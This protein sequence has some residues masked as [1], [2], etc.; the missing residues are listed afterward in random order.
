[1]FMGIINPLFAYKRMGTMMG[2]VAAT[3]VTITLH[4]APLND[5]TTGKLPHSDRGTLRRY[6]AYSPELK[7]NFTVDV[8]IPDGYDEAVTTRYPVLY[9]H[10]GQNLFDPSI[11]YAGVAW[12]VEQTLGNLIDRDIIKT[13]IVVGIHNRGSK[14][15]SDY[16]PAKPATDYIAADD[17]DASGMWTLVGNSFNGDAYATFIAKTLKPAIDA[18][19][20][21][22][23]DR[24]NTFIMGSS[25]GGL[26]SLYVMCEYPDIFGAAACLSTHWIGNFDPGSHIYPTAVL[27]YLNDNLPDPATHRLYFDRGTVDLD[28]YY[29]EWD[30]KAIALAKDKG[31]SCDGGSLYTFVDN[32]A[33]HNEAYWAARLDRPVHFLLHSTDEPYTPS[34][35]EETEFHVIFKDSE[36]SWDAPCAFVW[37][38]GVTQLGTWPGTPMT[39]IDYDGETAWSITFSHKIQPSNIIFNDGR[40]SGAVQTANL[41]FSNNYL[42]DFNGP[43]SPVYSEALTVER[44][45]LLRVFVSGGRLVIES[46]E[47]CTVPL[48]SVDG[49]TIMLQVKEGPNT[50][51][52]IV[53]GIYIVAGKKVVIR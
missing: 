36:Y 35:P 51:D 34:V 22:L 9:M 32:G 18:M 26:A 39:R 53:P 43:V 48:V 37:A 46:A 10:D 12:E 41:I 16:I 15:P 2:M 29:G 1:M 33:S 30:D 38:S 40:K 13:P 28:S 42:Y 25:M 24:D 21:T 11:S 8:L 6:T 52:S 27:D 23:S 7:G 47:A 19:F 31:Y 17:R 49:R 4:G 3:A 50:Y 5:V 45:G 44:G 20:R 14:R